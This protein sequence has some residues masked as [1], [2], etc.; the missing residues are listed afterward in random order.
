MRT[1]PTCA[2]AFT[3][4]EEVCPLDDA[5]LGTGDGTTRPGL[6][7]E[8]GSYRLT[9]LLGE[10]GMGAV[11]V[12]AHTRLKRHV[13]IKVLRS[14]LLHRK[15]SLARFFDEARTVNRL[16]HPHII[17]SIDLVEDVVDGAYC[18]LELL[19]GPDLKTR[20]GSGRIPL[21][22]VTHIGAQIA[23]ALSAVHAIDIVHRD[24]KP[25]NLILIRRDGRD[26]FVKLIDFGVA[27]ISD[28][29]AAGAP[30]GSAAYMAPEQAA[31]GRVDGRADLYALGVLLFEMATGQHP[32]PA[33]SDHEYVLHHADTPAPR[34]S[35]LDPRISRELDA[36]IA[37]CLA[38]A[39]AD[40]FPTATAVMTALRAITPSRARTGKARWI[41]FG[42][43]LAGVAA[44]AMV[45]VPR[46]FADDP[47]AVPPRTQV[48]AIVPAGTAAARSPVPAPAVPEIT[49]AFTTTP[50]GARVFRVGESVPLGTTPFAATFAR[51]MQR[52]TVRIEREGYQPTTSEIGLDTSHEIVTDLEPIAPPAAGSRKVTRPTPPREPKGRVQRE[53]TIDPFAPN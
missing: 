22:V 39:P 1:C 51:T 50:P 44:A 32:F 19:R 24:L 49:I 6:G 36:V 13:A 2:R 52:I 42:L 12:G 11:Y 9:C 20:L 16:K 5:R 53:G 4:S 26:D 34:A 46:W 23:D 10:G 41:A 18:V 17:E 27:Q 7:R 30:V 29:G 8:L 15:G 43:G 47:A 3:D 31:G 25:E 48:A 33:R 37:R 45:L 40:R 28:E 38:K 21:D 14:E 35:K